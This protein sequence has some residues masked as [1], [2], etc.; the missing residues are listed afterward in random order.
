MGGRSGL[1]GDGADPD[2]LQSLHLQLVALAWCRGMNCVLL[3]ILQGCWVFAGGGWP[4]QHPRVSSLQASEQ[5]K[6]SQVSEQPVRA[7][8]EP[9]ELQNS[10]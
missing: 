5:Q 2:C 3:S 4:L 10:L 7:E 6:Q 9:S 8:I 1:L